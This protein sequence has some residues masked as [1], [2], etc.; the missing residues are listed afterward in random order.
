MASEFRFPTTWAAMIDNRLDHSVHLLDDRDRA[1]ED[2]LSHLP[3][4]G[5]V[6]PASYVIAP[7]DASALSKGR[8]DAVLTG[9]SDEAI[10]NTIAASLAANSP[11]SGGSIVILEGN[12][13]LAGPVDLQY[14]FLRGVGINNTY[15]NFTASAA[16]QTALLHCGGLSDFQLFCNF[17]A[18]NNCVAIQTDESFATI[19]RIEAFV[20]TSGTGSIVAQFTTALEAV[21]S[22]CFF[23]TSSSATTLMSL[24]GR[25]NIV[26]N[27]FDAG[28]GIGIVTV[29]GT[30]GP[31]DTMI[32]GNLF[33]N[34]K[35]GAIV[36]GQSNTHYFHVTNNVFIQCG[37]ASNPVI[38]IAGYENRVTDN[39]FRL[40]DRTGGVSSGALYCIQIAATGANN[41]VTN[42]DCF[43]GYV[44]GAINNLGAGTVT[45]AGNR[46]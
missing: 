2:Y 37:N 41:F 28:G 21:V 42:N 20:S 39:L 11:F 27:Q 14:S 12:V 31:T 36:D 15:L 34:C 9:F 1:L 13:Q 30:N 26:N 23:G 45:V 19:D 43:N 24:V 32:V 5:G 10:I 3:T 29:A 4:G 8:A 6:T 25:I 40:R 16:S 46:P 18:N 33:T 17:G 22:N 38:S 7:S 44:T 35:G